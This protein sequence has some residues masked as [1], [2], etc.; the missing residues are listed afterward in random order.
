MLKGMD[1]KFLVAFE[2][3]KVMAVALVVPEKEILAMG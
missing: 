3:H 2:D 1:V